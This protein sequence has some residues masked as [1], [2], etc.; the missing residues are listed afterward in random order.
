MCVSGL[1]SGLR[2]RTFVFFMVQCV[3]KDISCGGLLF[4]LLSPPGFF[5]HLVLGCRQCQKA[6]AETN[7]RSKCIKL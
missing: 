6:A 2:P 4:T 1:C 7:A 3:K 5:T